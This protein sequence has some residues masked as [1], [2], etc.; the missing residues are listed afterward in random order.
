MSQI[1]EVK[2][3]SDIVE[4]IGSRIDLQRSGSYFKG[5]CPFH[6]ESSPSFFVSE[7]MQRYKCF[8]CGATGD[9]FTFLE[10]YEGMAF[11][12]ALQHLAE[13]AGITLKEFT[14]TEKDVLRDKLLEALNL[15]KEYYHYILTKH[16]AGS[17]AR[18][19][20]KNRGVNNESIRLF[21]LGYAMDS[22]DGLISYLH[23][24]KKYRLDLLEQ[25]GLVAK[26]RQ[27]RYYD[28][29][30]GR[31]IFPLTNHRG[32]VVGFSGRLL[33]KDAKEAKYINSP[34]TM[35]YHKSEL[36]F[37]Y[38]QLYQHI[39]EARRVVVVEG[40][41]DVITSQ[42]AHLN[43][44]VAIK[45]S[46]LTEEHAK[47]LARTVD[48]VLLS[49][50]TDQA[51]IEATRKAIRVLK[52]T[53]LELRVIQIPSGKDPDE[54]I[55]E[56]PKSWREA[57]KKSVTAPGFLIAVALSRHDPDTSEGKRGIMQE[58]A[59]VLADI[60]HAVELE[61]YL[62]ELSAVLNVKPEAIR[63][64]VLAYKKKERLGI[65][66]VDPVRSAAEPEGTKPGRWQITKT[67]RQAMEE[68]LLFLMLQM[69]PKDLHAKAVKLQEI[70]L[71][72]PGA[73]QLVRAL[74]EKGEAIAIENVGKSLPDDLQELLFDLLTHEKYF[75]GSESSL[76]AEKEWQQTLREI[77]VES[78]RE[79]ITAITDELSALD[80]KLNKTAEEKNRQNHLLKKIVELN[81][82][83]R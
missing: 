53:D 2:E 14:R 15:A 83:V 32:Q 35:L 47:L 77:M 4:L 51:G 34:E 68:Y 20:L 55:R 17:K 52:G 31:V 39:R 21:Q 49:L 16:D 72:I 64:D 78:T 3:A 22:W 66:K 45:G 74:A 48:T 43:N 60:T 63:E 54:L 29:F 1:R 26:N 73:T 12:E 9:V 75:S 79:K 18:D 71:T 30:R 59:P 69:K 81:R 42:Q 33:D 37:G 41:F 44:I 67:R 24:K 10:E 27:G 57:V 13:K 23:K 8:G 50:D 62:R 19:Y 36:L 7:Q 6:N 80:K 65:P 70:E 82:A 25:A 58:M 61:H 11:Y 56:N 28:R 46:A 76:D 38:S 40:E 5:L